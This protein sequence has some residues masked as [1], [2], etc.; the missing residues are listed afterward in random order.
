MDGTTHSGAARS[1][2]LPTFHRI[3]PLSCPPTSGHV[4]P[5]CLRGVMI[6]ILRSLWG[7]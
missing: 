4:S 3:T 5:T 6:E 1:R 7:P 2:T